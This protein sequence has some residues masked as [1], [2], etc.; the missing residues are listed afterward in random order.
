ME[1]YNMSDEQA[2]HEQ[3]IRIWAYHLWE[4]D[5]RPDGDD[6]G[7]WERAMSLSDRKT[8][9]V[10]QSEIMSSPGNDWR[11]TRR[12]ENAT[13]EPDISSF[14]FTTIPTL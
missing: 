10:D 8:L 12:F 4:N 14:Q 7:H 11:P 6:K 5:G 2:D 1:Q 13:G 3:R 9:E